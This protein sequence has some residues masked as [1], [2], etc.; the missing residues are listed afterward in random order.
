M[1]AA[2]A[3]DDPAFHAFGAGLDERARGLCGVAP[4]SSR[5][6]RGDA[7]SAHIRLRRERAPDSPALGPGQRGLRRTG[8][9]ADEQSASGKPVPPATWTEISR[10]VESALALPLAASGR[11]T[12][13][14][15]RSLPVRPPSEMRTV[16]ASAAP[17]IRRAQSG[18]RI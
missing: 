4:S 2:C 7:R 18:R 5:R 3:R 12:M 14:S 17:P 6:R 11:A 1:A 10:L 8:G 13:H 9:N 15:G 16:A